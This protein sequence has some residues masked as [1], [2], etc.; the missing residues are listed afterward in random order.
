MHNI[1]LITDDRVISRHFSVFSLSGFLFSLGDNFMP[2]NFQLDGGH[3][4]L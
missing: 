3:G 2:G 4:E 1:F